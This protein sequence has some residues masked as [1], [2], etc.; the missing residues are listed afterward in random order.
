MPFL[1]IGRSRA[2]SR[3]SPAPCN[4]PA[5]IVLAAFAMASLQIDAVEPCTIPAKDALTLFLGIPFK[6]PHHQAHRR[7]V[8]ARDRAYG[9]IRSDH[10]TLDA[11]CPYDDV[12]VHSEIVRPPV[13]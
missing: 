3:M 4:T 1:G 9:P 8:V 2:S 11:K 5:L 10:Q 6:V 13:C 7:L 12:K